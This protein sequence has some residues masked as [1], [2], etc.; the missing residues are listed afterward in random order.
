MTTVAGRLGLADQHTSTFGG[1]PAGIGRSSRRGDAAASPSYGPARGRTEQ[2]TV[3][4]TPRWHSGT[5]AAGATTSDIVLYRDGDLSADAAVL[6]ILL[7]TAASILVK[8]GLTFASP[9]RRFA[10]RVAAYSTVLLLAAG[11]V[12]AVA[13][14]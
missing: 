1:R 2:F 13:T 14:V 11:T 3:R 10:G 7:A 4:Q 12:T 5:S 8:A 9:D 6:A